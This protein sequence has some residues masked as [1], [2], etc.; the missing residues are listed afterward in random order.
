MIESG[1][2]FNAPG[3]YFSAAVA[4]DANR[5]AASEGARRLHRGGFGKASSI[6]WALICPIANRPL[7]MARAVSRSGRSD[8]HNGRQ[9]A[10]QPAA[11]GRAGATWAGTSGTATGSSGRAGRRGWSRSRGSRPSSRG[12]GSYGVGAVSMRKIAEALNAEGIPA[13]T[14][15]RWRH[16]AVRSN[17]KRQ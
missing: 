6:Y 7:S 11:Q 17:L 1:L 3:R 10:G 5:H 12:L 2:E 14:G 9:N 16:A 4:E 13:R 8:R 15:G